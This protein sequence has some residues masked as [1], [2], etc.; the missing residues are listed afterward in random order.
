MGPWIKW[1]QWQKWR[2]YMDSKIHVLLLTKGWHSYICNGMS[3]LTWHQRPTMSSDM[4]LFPWRPASNLVVGWPLLSWEGQ[5]FVL[6][7]VYT[8]SVLDLLFLHLMLLLKLP[9]VNFQNTLSTI[10]VFYTALL[11]IKEL[12]HSH[13]SAPAGPH[14]CNP[15]A[16]YH[17]PTI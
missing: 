14:V 1:P 5:C 8:H 12:I 6:I 16:F 15:L 3:S 17:V 2:L 9:S 4:L 10:M 7:G 11:L 13:R